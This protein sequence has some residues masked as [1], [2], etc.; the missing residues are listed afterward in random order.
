MHDQLGHA[1][2][3]LL[4]AGAVLG[5]A[6]I[7][8]EP[9]S[10]TTQAFSSTGTSAFIVPASVTSVTVAA[11]GAAG[12]SH[13]CNPGHLGGR[14]AT[15]TATIPV[16]PGEILAIG[17][18]AKG[19]GCNQPSGL[20]GAGGIGGGAAGGGTG[21][22]AG[23][24]AGGGGAT[25]VSRVTPSIAFA[26]VLLVAG[27][28][29]GVGGGF[30][31][32][33]GDAGSAGQAGASS[34]ANSAGGDGGTTAGGGAGGLGNGALGGSR[35]V[36]FAGG[37]GASAGSSCGGGGGGGGYYGGG[38]GGAANGFCGGGGGG[39]G[40]SYADSSVTVTSKP[41]PTTQSP[42]LTITYGSS[43]AT[44]PKVLHG[45]VQARSCTRIYRAT[46][47]TTRVRTGAVSLTAGAAKAVLSSNGRVVAR[48]NAN[49]VRVGTW[50]LVLTGTSRLRA[51]R[52]TLRLTL[53]GGHV[54][55]FTLQL[56]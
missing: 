49:R 32:S 29:G 12:G 56:S 54:L 53:A 42:G 22:A 43:T 45:T 19:G 37:V 34:G 18:G 4:V 14:G 27:G 38:G 55:A 25:Y 51:G 35:G 17:V 6:A 8:A 50:R 47:C 10:A 1:A 9:A 30:G 46:H 5:T 40:A 13:L 23:A 44:G 11:V 28:G 20:G 48:G 3:R 15:V 33:G 36:A 2:R 7:I 31:G 24:A 26:S 21:T 41:Q 52:Y 39:G 16:N